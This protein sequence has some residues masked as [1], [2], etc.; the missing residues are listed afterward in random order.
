[1][2]GTKSDHRSQITDHRSQITD[3]RSR[4]TD[5]GSRITDHRF[6]VEVRNLSKSFR[7]PSGKT[8]PVLRDVSFSIAAG[9]L[10]AIT[11]ASGAGKS[12]LLHLLGG[13]ETQDSGTIDFAKMDSGAIDSA[14]MDSGTIDFAKMDGGAIDSGAIDFGGGRLKSPSISFVFQFH[15]LL[16]DL[17]ALENVSL[18]LRIARV[19]NKEARQR[20][21]RALDAVGLGERH[22]HRIGDLSGGEQQRVAVV[23]ALITEPE[24]V[25]ADEPT[26]NLDT[27]IAAEIGALFAD[28]ARRRQAAVII[29]THNESLAGICDR[30]LRLEDGQISES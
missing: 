28:Y 27:S 24:I 18:P 2:I 12:T 5:H 4:I 1:V 7:S 9:E 20:A 14:K 25:L 10:I 16:T 15:Y 29:A 6:Q 11:G 26:G 22:T 13:L 17:S 30:V 23:R 19:P 8:I 3:L 21:L